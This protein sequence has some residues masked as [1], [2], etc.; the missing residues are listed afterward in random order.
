MA[1]EP[2]RAFRPTESATAPP[3]SPSPTSIKTA[4]STSPSP[5]PPP[6]RS[7]CSST[8]GS[9]ERLSFPSRLSFPLQSATGRRRLRRSSPSND[10]V[11]RR[12][13]PVLHFPAPLLRGKARLV[14][15]LA[16]RD[17]RVL[18]SPPRH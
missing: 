18:A 5:R 1:R 15:K 6:T 8:G 12:Q 11:D 16:P 10:A 9:A 3:G 14:K 4:P 17:C 7:P 2:S 13:D